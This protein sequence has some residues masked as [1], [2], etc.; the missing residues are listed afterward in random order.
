MGGTTPLVSRLHGNLWVSNY[1]ST[2]PTDHDDGS[3]GYLDTNNVL[4]W[5]GTKSLMGYAKRH[6]GNAMV[7]V[8][9]SPALNAPAA[10]RVGW[11]APEGKPPMCSGMITP[12]PGAG[13]DVAE[14]WE[15]NTCIA[16]DARFFF[17]WE[18]CNSSAPL[19][20]GVPVPLRGNRYHTPNA[21]YQLRC[22]GALWTL[23][24]AQQQGLDLG[25]TLHPLPTLQEL[26]AL[27][28][29]LLGL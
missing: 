3:H 4:L 20:G 16:S 21:T 23:D 9:Y 1:F 27:L 8:D 13:P 10:R 28:Q 24:Q 12:T 7:Y 17:R 15:N 26:L 14:A 18:S 22:G 11:S 5:G 19:D 25:A 6:I 29:G 2:V